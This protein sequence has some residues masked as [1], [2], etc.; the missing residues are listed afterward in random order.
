MMPFP[1]L[2]SSLSV[3]LCLVWLGVPRV[4]FAAGDVPRAEAPR[5]APSGSLAGPDSPEGVEST[6]VPER[7]RA[8]RGLRLLTE[9]GTGL[10]TSAGGGLSLGLLG[11]GLCQV[12]QLGYES[13][14]L[15]CGGTA[16][17]GAVLGVLAGYPLGVWWGGELRGGDGSLLSSILGGAVGLLVGSAVTALA[18]GSGNESLYVLPWVA[19]PVL[20]VTG[21]HLGYELFQRA[22]ASRASRPGLQPVL[23]FSSRGALLGVG[24]RF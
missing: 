22:P 14:V 16:A 13:S 10:L 9:V 24:G 2:A 1:R 11:Y 6:R 15:G 5:L 8:S 20:F 3:L 23:S 17:L 7:P 19:V 21:A 12:T 18:Y 4:G